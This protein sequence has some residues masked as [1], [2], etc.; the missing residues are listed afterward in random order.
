MIS[1]SALRWQAMTGMAH[2]NIVTVII[3]AFTAWRCGN[4]HTGIVAA[5][6]AT[7]FCIVSCLAPMTDTLPA[8]PMIT[9]LQEKITDA[10]W[11]MW[12]YGFF[13][14][15]GIVYPL[16]VPMWVHA[17]YERFTQRSGSRKG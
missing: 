16:L 12:L 2:G 10:G 15:W 3:S 7:V 11:L 4:E 13:L 17:Y 8:G 9:L 5:C 1:Q 6:I 14:L